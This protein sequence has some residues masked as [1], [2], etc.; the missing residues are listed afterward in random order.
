MNLH[1]KQKFTGVEKHI[2]IKR[3]KGDEDKSEG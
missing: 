1:I 3:E 2:V